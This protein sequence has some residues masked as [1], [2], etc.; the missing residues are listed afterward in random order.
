MDIIP[1]AI[2]LYILAIFKLSME[3]SLGLNSN[4][5][6]NIPLTIIIQFAIL[7]VFF[8]FTAHQPAEPACTVS[9]SSASQKLNK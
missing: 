4:F 5:L 9:H 1:F 6:H 8:H 7:A 2:D 3:D